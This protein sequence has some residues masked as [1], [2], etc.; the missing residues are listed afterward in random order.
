MRKP[1]FIKMIKDPE[2]AAY[3]QE[4]RQ[5]AAVQGVGEYLTHLYSLPRWQ[6]IKYVINVLCAKQSVESDGSECKTIEEI[7]EGKKHE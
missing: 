7:R 5:E 2:N 3:V 4:M 6:R 1:Q